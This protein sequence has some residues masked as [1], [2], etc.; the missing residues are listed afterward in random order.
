VLG[1]PVDFS[2]TEDEARALG[3]DALVAGSSLEHGIFGAYG[4]LGQARVAAT[5]RGDDPAADALQL[6]VAVTSFGAFDDPRRA[7]GPMASGTFEDGRPWRCSIPT[8][9]TD[10]HV[11]A[12]EVLIACIVTPVMRARLG[13]VL[14][15]VARPRNPSHARKAI[16]AYLSVAE[17]TFDPDHW[18]TSHQHIARAFVLATLLGWDSP[19]RG[20]V[21]RTAFAFLERL[22]G[23]DPRYYTQRLIEMLLEAVSEPTELRRLLARAQSIAEQSATQGDF[24]RSRAYYESAVPIARR[25]DQNDVAHDLRLARAETYVSEALTRPTEMLRSF[26]L[27]LALHALRQAGAV[28]E[29]RD[30]VAQMLDEAQ[31]VAVSEMSAV[32]TPIAVG[33]SSDLVRGML[34]GRE[35]IEALWLLSGIG[36]LPPADA[37]RASAEA[38]LSQYHFAFGFARRHLAADGRQVG[39]TPG[40]LGA[41]NDE[42]E[43]AVQGAM[44]FNSAHSRLLAVYGFIEPGRRQLVAEHDFTLAE[45]REAVSSRPFIP[46]GHEV[47]WAKGIH[48]GLVGEFDLAVHILA[49]QLENA[50]REVLRRHGNIIYSTSSS[51]VQSLF[52]LE[53]ILEDPATTT[54]FGSDIVF[55]LDTSLAERLGANVRNEVAHGIMNDGTAQSHEA[56]FVWWLALRVLRFYGPDAL[57]PRS[58]TQQSD[59]PG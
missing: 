57:A 56:V 7:F 21:V 44:R 20:E 28:R 22:E 27:R 36:V 42:Y 39:E 29:R 33:Q 50:L 51:G 53:R 6:L 24:D 49:P 35:P 11:A 15:N 16:A 23:Y 5:E 10:S 18:P 32:N 55:A 26:D 38:S 58:A 43:R 19:E 46:H 9:L 14:W 31:T 12:L 52:A 13:D 37:V 17:T 59:H 3:I 34:R 4:A 54:I 47:L 48:A 30:E 45:V 1:L 2:V 41:E 40:A 25:L 8:D